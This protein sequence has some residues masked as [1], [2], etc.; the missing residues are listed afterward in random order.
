V[1]APSLSDYP[2]IRGQD[3]PCIRGK[4]LY[5]IA[6]ANA[7]RCRAVEFSTAIVVCPAC[8]GTGR[9]SPHACPECG[10]TGRAR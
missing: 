10:G 3:D 6:C 4:C 7:G 2:C 5:P 9:A 8:E 1:T